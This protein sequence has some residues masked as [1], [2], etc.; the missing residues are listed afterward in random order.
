MTKRGPHTIAPQT[1]S[2]PRPPARVI[3]T[4]P[5]PFAPTHL[6]DAQFTDGSRTRI[7]VRLHTAGS[8][9][10]AYTRDEWNAFRSHGSVDWQMIGGQW[11][12]GGAPMAAVKL[13]PLD[14]T[15]TRPAAQFTSSVLVRCTPE[16]A[17]RW[18]RAAEVDPDANGNA[19]DFMRRAL[20]EAADFALREPSSD[21]IGVA[22]QHRDRDEARDP[23]TWTCVCGA[24]VKVR[25]NWQR[26]L[27]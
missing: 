3:D 13:R 15:P 18:R 11:L 24:C 4:N 12:C 10:V 9:T 17:E 22:A 21:D 6:L 7:R 1:N 25:G 14:A 16:Q 8:K 27:P 2:D 26:H 5:V 19:Q 23:R 20:D